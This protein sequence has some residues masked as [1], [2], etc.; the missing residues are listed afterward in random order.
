LLHYGL[1]LVV[2]AAAAIMLARAESFD[3]FGL[4]AVA[5]GLDAL[6]VGGL[7]YAMFHDLRGDGWFAALL[8]TGLAAAG[9]VA[10]TVSALLRLAR[11]HGA[12]R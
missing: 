9:L 1:G 8:V 2:L 4:S 3:I 7:A 6:L 5:L 10:A 11:R 12:P